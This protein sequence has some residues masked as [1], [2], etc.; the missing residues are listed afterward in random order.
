MTSEGLLRVIH[1]GLWLVVFLSA[2]AISA[3]IVTGLGVAV[4]QA[5]TQIQE[6]TITFVPKTLAVF[7]TLVIAG[8]WMGGTIGRYAVLCWGSLSSGLP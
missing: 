3:S 4:L 8:P 2:P 1:E 5:I 6:Q 7:G